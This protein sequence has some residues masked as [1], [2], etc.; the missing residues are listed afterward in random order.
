LGT[1]AISN[2]WFKTK[3]QSSVRDKKGYKDSKFAMASALVNCPKDVWEKKDIEEATD[4][5]SD[6]IIKFIFNIKEKPAV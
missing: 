2:E 3:K 6:R 4:N 1:G 5:I